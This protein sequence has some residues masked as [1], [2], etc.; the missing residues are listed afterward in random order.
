MQT[1]RFFCFV[2]RYAVMCECWNSNPRKRPTFMNLVCI[3]ERLQP[4]HKV[5]YVKLF[6]VF[7]VDST[8]SLSPFQPNYVTAVCL[9]QQNIHGI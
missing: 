4:R 7:E 9:F 5:R 1:V 8:V 2:E 6:H 3:L